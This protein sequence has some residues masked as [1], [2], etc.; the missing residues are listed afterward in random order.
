MPL[1]ALRCAA[2]RSTGNVFA[3][4]ALTTP[5]NVEIPMATKILL[6]ITVGKK[7]QSQSTS[8]KQITAGGCTVERVE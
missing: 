7:H 8:K 4:P 3:N 5:N 2:R 6:A 1:I